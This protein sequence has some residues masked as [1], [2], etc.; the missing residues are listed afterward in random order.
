[1]GGASRKRI[2]RHNIDN[3]RNLAVKGKSDKHL[4]AERKQPLQKGEVKVIEEIPQK[5][6]VGFVR[7][8]G[9]LSG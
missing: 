2:S 6:M 9:S 1:M 8:P 5:E 4:N 3:L 7:F